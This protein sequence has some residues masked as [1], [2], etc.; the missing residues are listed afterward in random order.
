MTA[1]LC[2]ALATLCRPVGLFILGPIILYLIFRKNNFNYRNAL[3]LFPGIIL[4]VFWVIR[5]HSISGIY[6]IASVNKYNI[7][8]TMAVS[9]VAHKE[10]KPEFEVRDSLV[11][12]INKVIGEDP[13][14]CS[15]NY[16]GIKLYS[17]KGMEVIKEYPFTYSWLHLK[18]TW[19]NLIPP[20]TSILET[21]DVTKGN[22]NSLSVLNQKGLFSAIEHYFGKKKILI[23][24]F[25]P[26][27]F[28]HFLMI[29]G[30]FWGLIK[31]VVEKNIALFILLGGISLYL[32]L[33]P[34]PAS[35]PRFAEPVAPI[36]ALLFGV[37]AQ[38]L[39]YLFRNL[40]RTNWVK[41]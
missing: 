38:S 10:C 11:K 30:W 1:G 9:I 16:H 25:I 5:N 15:T 7:Y 3:F 18:N 12:S 36:F 23:L 24:A 2:W 21:W 6:T 35:V 40:L 39:S 28:L 31:L 4:I 41:Y 32:L 37:S 22:S 34:G 20:I 26:W 13:L 14:F 8:A 33:I 29:A 27:I 19:H 17:S